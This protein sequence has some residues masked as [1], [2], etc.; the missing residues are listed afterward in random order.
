MACSC[1]GRK[2]TQYVWTSADGKETSVYP[3]EIQAK[4]KTMRAGGTYTTKG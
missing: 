2:S 4:A 1:K 3:S